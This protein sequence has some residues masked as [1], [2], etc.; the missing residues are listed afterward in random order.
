MKTTM[1]RWNVSLRA[2]MDGNTLHGE[3]AVFDQI[4]ETQDGPE[5]FERSAFDVVLGNPD[6]DTV[7]LFNH[8]PDYLLGR[9]SAGTLALR[10]GESLIFDIDLP[11]TQWGH[12]V[13]VLTQRGDLRG[14]SV[15]F[16]AGHAEYR[17]VNGIRVNAH[18]SVA[19]LR[20][21]SPV[22][23][24]AYKGTAGSLQMRS[25]QDFGR[26]DRARSQRIQARARVLLGK[27]M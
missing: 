5:M 27:G 20:D 23:F 6:S 4:A 11:D 13:R 15:G 2:E 24:P 19:R 18:S 1:Q 22:T 26:S 16:I 12:D 25:V 3:A 17:S 10:S 21:I 8:N 14:A 7:A 9:Q